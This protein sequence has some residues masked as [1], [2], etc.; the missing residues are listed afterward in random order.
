LALPPNPLYSLYK[1]R[2]VLKDFTVRFPNNQAADTY[3]VDL[4]WAMECNLEDIVVDVYNQIPPLIAPPWYNAGIIIPDAAGAVMT[5]RNCEV[6][7]FMFGFL[8]GDFGYLENCVAEYCVYSFGIGFLGIMEHQVTLLHC[9]E[10][11][12][13]H[14]VLLG[15]HVQENASLDI[16]GYDIEIENTGIWTRQ[17]GAEETLP[18]FARGFV[19]YTTINQSLNVHYTPFWKAGSG[20]NFKT[21]WGTT[22][23]EMKGIAT[24]V[25]ST[26]TT[27]DHHLATT[28]TLVLCSFNSTTYGSY[29]WT[30]TTTQITVTVDTSGYY[31]VYW[32]AEV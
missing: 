25:G 19:S 24:I 32:L 20:L 2:I 27:F 6:Y 9:I 23:S 1:P 29:K 15:S 28:P 12:C 4:Q 5:A 21:V 18:G 10:L 7:G 14:S 11:S 3:G 17:G 26:T 30:A 31:T 13:Q 22:G 16:I 8:V